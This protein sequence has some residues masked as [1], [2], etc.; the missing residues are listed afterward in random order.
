VESILGAPVLGSVR[1]DSQAAKRPL[2]TALDSHHPRVEAFRVLRTNLQFVDVDQPSKVYA[3]SSS[4]P[5]EG[6]TT[7]AANLAITLAQTGA[8]VVLV[9][10]DLRRPKISEYLRAEGAVGLTTVLIGLIDLADAVQHFG[11]DGLQV[12][13]S[14]ANPPNPAELL[15]S[16]GMSDVIAKLR[17]AYD[18]VLL[19]APPL[20][21]VTDA[22]LVGVQADGVLLVVRHGVTTRAQLREAHDRL[23]NVGARVVGAVIN[24]APVRGSDSYGYSYGYG[25]GYGQ[26]PSGGRPVTAP[27][28]TESAGQHRTNAVGSTASGTTTDA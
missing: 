27:A 19:D 7:T 14:G 25:Y 5:E 21:P 9:E 20:L 22:A 26:S 8:R 10:T 28:V 1:F 17:Q 23:A 24:R 11:D 4:I 16:R 15:Q 6:K 18:I 13:T 2:V 12:I 3:V